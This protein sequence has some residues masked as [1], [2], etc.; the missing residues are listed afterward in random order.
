M[1]R[2][3]IAR[4][5]RCWRARGSRSRPTSMIP[6]DFV[7]WKP[8]KPNEPGWPSPAG[9]AALGRPG[10]HIECSAMSMATL[11]EPFGGGLQ[12]D[13]PG[14]NTFDI[15]GGGIDLVFPHHENEIAQSCCAFGSDRMANVWMHN[16]FLQVEGEKM[17]KSAGNFVTIR[18]L[19]REAKFGNSTW[20][21]DALRLAMLRT[22]YRQPIDW[23][24]REL[25]RAHADL[26]EWYGLIDD[27]SFNG[28]IDPGVLEALSD[29]LNT[30]GALVRVHE[31]AKG[32]DGVALRASLSFLGFSCNSANLARRVL[33]ASARSM[34]VSSVRLP[35]PSLLQERAD[36]PRQSTRMRTQQH[37]EIDSERGRDV[38]DGH[39]HSKAH[40]RANRAPQSRS[41]DT[42]LCG[43]RRTSR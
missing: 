34:N 38:L 19:L 22:H 17:A 25:E 14:L 4:S 36:R 35:P 20:S 29:D 33:S 31:L 42:E 6:M 21:G 18:E 3:R 27:A 15:H 1:A 26:G 32:G 7:L 2:S 37:I 12:C 10:W 16:G 23:T 30:H 11:V 28:M 40:R 41:C 13:D 9:I 5:T 8:S 43:S 39:G 24:V